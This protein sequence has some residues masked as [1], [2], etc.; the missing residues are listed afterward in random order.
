MFPNSEHLPLPR[1]PVQTPLVTPREV[2]NRAP[3]LTLEAP[4]CEPNIGMFVIKE[5]A[6]SL[7]WRCWCDS[8]DMELFWHSLEQKYETVLAPFVTGIWNCFGTVLNR[9]MEL[10]LA[11]L[12]TP[13]I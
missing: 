8:R 3:I 11:Q 9:D 13:K 1:L 10:F 2:Y 5:P 6:S 4:I 7:Q 12:G